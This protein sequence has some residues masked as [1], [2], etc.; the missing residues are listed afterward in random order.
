[1][2][3]MKLARYEKGVSLAQVSE[4]TGLSP[5]SLSRYERGVV[6]PSAS[7]ARLL[8]DYYGVS[9]ARLLGLEPREPNGDPVA[10]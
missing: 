3:P 10:A 9:V 6:L 2:N 1:M 5:S 8:A 4:A 7:A